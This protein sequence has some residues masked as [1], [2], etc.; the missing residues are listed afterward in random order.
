[1]N[2]DGELVSATSALAEALAA[3]MHESLRRRF[4]TGRAFAI[5]ADERLLSEPLV[6]ELVERARARSLAVVPFEQ[7][8]AGFVLLTSAAPGRWQGVD[9]ATLRAVRRSVAAMCAAAAA[10]SEAEALIADVHHD[11]GNPLHAMRLHLELLLLT[12]PERD[13]RASRAALETLHGIAR[14]VSQVLGELDE[15]L[16]GSR[17]GGDDPATNVRDVI[18]EV[19]ATLSPV[20]AER[21]IR[22][23]ARALP[24]LAAIP[25]RHLFRALSNVVVNAIKYADPSTEVTIGAEL[26]GE[27]IRVAVDDRGPGI[28][29]ADC[30]RLLDARWLKASGV[31]KG[32]GLGLAIAKR[33]VE[34][35]GGTISI[36]SAQGYGT[37]GVIELMRAHKPVGAHCDSGSPTAAP[38]RHDVEAGL[39][40]PAQTIP[41]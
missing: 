39:A 4:A 27:R 9:G 14:R 16:H 13:R 24:A 11:L 17:R 21:E 7:H 32:R 26:D 34:S 38:A 37:R 10:R 1:M 3:S 18:D 25:S 20:A 41:T 5:E 23:V 28:A 36:T 29:C 8:L 33:L 31:R 35:Y 15:Y 30:A 12:V 6:H 40:T 22:L 2:D 19:I